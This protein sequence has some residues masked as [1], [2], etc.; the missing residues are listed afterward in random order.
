MI[1]F[2]G[3][4][5]LTLVGCASSVEAPSADLPRR[6]V[7]VSASAASTLEARGATVLGDYGSFKVLRIEASLLDE[8]SMQLKDEFDELRLNAGTI[9]TKSA[10]AQSLRGVVAQT[11]GKRLHL[12]QFV[13]P[14]KAEWLQSL[15]ETG[16]RV[17]GYVPNNAYLVWGDGPALAKVGA[18][19]HAATTTVQWDG[20]FL[21]DYRLSPSVQTVVTTT[22]EVQL[23]KEPQVNAHTLARIASLESRRVSTQE[24][25]GYVNV[26]SELTRAQLNELVTE[27]DIVSIHPHPMPHQYDERQGILMTGAL[28]AGA[29]TAPGYLAWL[30]SKGFT[31]AQFTASGVGVDVSDTGLDNG[32]VTPNHFGLYV[33]GD[34]TNASRVAYSRLE[35]T[36]HTG[37]TL[38]GCDGHGTINAHIIGGYVSQNVAPFVDGSGFAF[39]LGVAP[40]VRVGASVVF[41]PK[42]TSPQVENLQ[43]R[44][45]AAG[46]RVSSNSWGAD[47]NDYDSMCQRYD[48]LVRDAQPAGSAVPAAGNQSMIIVFAAGNSG[49]EAGTIGSPGGAKNV[50]AVGAAEGVQALGGSDRCGVPDDQANSVLDV[51]DFSSRG[52]TVDG[53]LKPDLMAPG[54]HISGGVAQTEGQRASPPAAAL[55]QALSCFD[56]S[57]VCGGASS[58]FFPPTQQW[59][60]TSSGTSHSCPAVAGASA[61]LYQ[62]FLNGRLGPPS[63]AMNKAWL[64]NSARHMTGVGAND[65]LYSNNQGMGLTDLGRALDGVTRRLDDQS[66][67]HLLTATGQTRTFTGTIED[68]TKPFRVTLAWTDA[69]G[70]TVGSAWNNNLDLSV[71][72]NDKTYRGNVFS[73]AISIEGGSADSKNNVESVFLPAGVTGTYAVTV[74]AAN[75][76]SDGVPGNATPLDQDFALVVYNVCSTPALTGVTAQTNGNNRIDLSWAAT[77][78]SSYTV[79]RALTAGGPYTTLASVAAAS[80]S[81]TTV[82]GGTKYFYVVRGVR[83]AESG[84]SNEVSATATGPC[85]FLPVFA[86][87]GGVVSANTASCGQTLKWAAG[88]ASC[89]GALSYSV[90]RSASPGFAPSFANRIA[91]GVTGTSFIDDLNLVDG[92]SYAYLVRAV[93]TG[94]ARVE[95]TNLV[96]GTSAVSGVATA[97]QF[98]DDF[99]ANRPSNPLGYYAAESSALKVVSGCHSQSPTSAY[100]F[101]AANTSCGGSYENNVD[102]RLKLGGEGG[103]RI[104]SASAPTMSFN[105]WH[106]FETSFDGALLEYSTAGANGPFTQVGDAVSATAP[107]ISANGYQLAQNDLR[108]WTGVSTPANGALKSVSVNLSALRGKRVWFAFRFVTDPLVNREGLYLDDVRIS[109]ETTAACSTKAAPP[110]PAVRYVVTLANNVTAG[111]AAQID[112][113]AYDALGQRAQASP[114]AL[115]TSDGRATVPASMT[116]TNGVATTSV[117]FGTTGTHSVTVTDLGNAAVMGMAST[118]VAAGAVAV[119]VFTTQPS[120]AVA[121]A[122]V[123]PSVVVALADAYGNVATGSS[124]VT[125]GLAT[126]PGQ[127]VLGGTTS[128]NA[129]NGAATFGNL[130][131]EKAGEGYTLTASVPSLPSATSEKFT[132]R[133]GPPAAVAFATVPSQAVSGAPFDV[134]VEVRDALSNAVTTVSPSVTLA[135]GAGAQVGRLDG[136][137]TMTASNGVAA[138]TGLSIAPTGQYTLTASSAGL[139]SATSTSFEVIEGVKT[140]LVFRSNSLAAVAGATMAQ[141]EVAILN[142]NGQVVTNS[143]DS[144]SLELSTGQLRGTTSVAAVAGV[145][146]FR[147]LSVV[148]AGR[149]Y[150]LRAVSDALS[151]TSAAFDITAG[152]VARYRV[153]LPENATNGSAVTALAAAHDEFGNVVSTYEAQASVLCT[154]AVA[155]LPTA[156]VPFVKGLAQVTVMFKTEGTQTLI[157]TDSLNAKITGWGATAVS[158][159]LLP[160]ATV[161]APSQGAA[162]SG[163]VQVTAVG[164]A[165]R[166]RMLSSLAILIDGQTVATGASENLSFE[167]DTSKVTVGSH[168]VS[169]VVSDSA[170]FMGT[171]PVVTVTSKAGCGCN[172]GAGASYLLGLLALGRLAQ[173]R[174]VPRRAR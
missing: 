111:T 1:R 100:R 166:G 84:A 151:A 71:K 138:F 22:Y 28:T 74:T 43:S 128:V 73:G 94:V 30:S 153:T 148:V 66:P 174:R 35:G 161:T 83:C 3:V 36:P 137:T 87:L 57:G 96:V 143:T 14:V 130:L 70:S 145:A 171:S 41:D 39:G 150:T 53:R 167:W 69:P 56:A 55:G 97:T 15:E 64:M 113:T 136:P 103:F 44:A 58:K 12:V 68:A 173:R 8:A 142:M 157:L 169:A 16:V 4:C 40:F 162:V 89:G 168:E 134:K 106:H 34:V 63:P 122:R 158:A 48:A 61:L 33:G 109:T 98:F 51:V 86:G 101:G 79:Y 125:L 127:G 72:V 80:Y 159:P 50:I 170:G 90:Y 141:V 19:T 77:N 117:T 59:Y 119:V 9:N 17:L 164:S 7:Q 108:L 54:T 154:D 112:V 81:D 67:E 24:A 156:P 49:P 37:S 99:D 147:D 160:V 135:L 118:N 155:Q 18:F 25:L 149:D 78:A 46:M 62:W 29:P 131:I 27:P 85:T 95:D 165:P 88:A 93:E 45:F 110:G 132:V 6:T 133:A 52:P 114:A 42:F 104:S 172:S 13:A 144:V 21:P 82:S 75:I 124:V 126:N 139:S 146:T 76:N 60:S 163:K 120:D 123:T 105:L 116:F 129:I 102:T 92:A 121:G 140:Q 2:G 65:S 31:Q 152:P 47:I 20:A 107:Y 91:Q 11:R 5:A 115:K 26:V 32:T 38:A 23:V 10:M